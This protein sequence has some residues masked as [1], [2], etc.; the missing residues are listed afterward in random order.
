[1]H[2]VTCGVVLLS[3][4]VGGLF[5]APEQKR[6][7]KQRLKIEFRQAETSPGEGLTEATV[8][9]TNKKIYMHKTAD[10]TT[11]DISEARPGQ[12]SDG[13]PVVEIFLTKEGAK[14]LG[15]LTEK[16]ISKP[17][18]ILIDGKLVM[19]PVVRDRISDRAVIDGRFTEQERDKLVKEINAK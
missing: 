1:M 14:R 9:G 8:P 12:D 15:E 18:A 10:V 4:L 17:L 6:D 5:Q 2:S 11:A 19:A 7:E 13:K 3:S 16:Q